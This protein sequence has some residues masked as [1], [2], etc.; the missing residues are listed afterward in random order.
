MK[1]A[2]FFVFIFMQFLVKRMSNNRLVPLFGVG[3]LWQI[4][5][6]PLLNL[7]NTLNFGSI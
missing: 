3:A 2:N 6:A 7:L 5:D 1:D 4:P